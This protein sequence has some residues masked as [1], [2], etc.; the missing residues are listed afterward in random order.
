[1]LKSG[2]LLYS[3]SFAHP[4]SDNPDGI[5]GWVV[6]PAYPPGYPNNQAFEDG[7]GVFTA[8]GVV[9]NTKV[10]LC[11]GSF[12]QVEDG[13]IYMLY[14]SGTPYLWAAESHDDGETWTLP[15]PTLFTDNRTKF[16]LGQ[17]PS[18]KYYYVGTP[19]PFPPRTRH[20]LALSLSDNGLDYNQHFLL[21]DTQYKGKYLGYDKNGIYGYPSTMIHNGYLYVAFSICKEQIRCLRVPIDTL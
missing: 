20:V 18:G 8:T 1:M 13:T 14:R 21:D 4:Y 15:Q 19:D 16:H 6:N 2:R 9:S 10:G 3:G 12:V 11:E 17:L 5:H 7:E